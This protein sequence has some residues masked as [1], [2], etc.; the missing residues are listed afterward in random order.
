MAW[1]PK[2]MSGDTTASLRQFTA[3][4]AILNGVDPTT[5][6]ATNADPFWIDLRDLFLYGEQWV[7]GDDIPV[8]GMPSTDGPRRYPP[9]A[10][11]A[12]IFPD[13]ATN[14]FMRQDGVVS[15]TVM[16]DQSDNTLATSAPTRAV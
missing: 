8:I 16:G 14:V 7:N 11:L 6:P 10:D 9:V 2:A 12:Q 13:S 1:L 5:V 15:L 4:N 3:A